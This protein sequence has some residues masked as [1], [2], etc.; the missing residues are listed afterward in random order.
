MDDL[1]HLAAILTGHYPAYLSFLKSL[2]A[3][4]TVY[5]NDS[6]LDQGIGFCREHIN[7][8]LP[9]RQTYI[10]EAG[11][12]ISLDPAA[13]P[14]EPLVYLSAHIDTVPADSR[15]WHPK[16]SPFR[17]FEDDLEIVGRGV[18]DCKAGVAFQLFLATLGR[19]QI[20]LSPNLVLTVTRREEQG[21]RSAQAIAEAIGRELPAGPN[22]YV[23][24]LENTTNAASGELQMFHGERSSFAIELVEK[25]KRLKQFLLDDANPWNPTSICPVADLIPGHLQ[26]LGQSGGHAASVP[27][28]RNLLYQL[29]IGEDGVNQAI[30]SGDPK[31]V[32]AIPTRVEYWTTAADTVHRATFDLRTT[33]NLE[34]IEREF[35]IQDLDFR[36][37]K[38]SPYG[39]DGKAQF[40]GSDMSGIVG[41]LNEAG[42]YIVTG[43]GPGLTDAGLFHNAVDS[44]LR[45]H[46]VAVAC[47]PGTG[48]Q[49]EA[50]PPRLTH[51]VNETF[52]KRS[53]LDSMIWIS[54]LLAK[55]RALR[56]PGSSKL[57]S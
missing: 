48:S 42:A 3:I 22:L 54:N 33:K 46:F 23:I 52:D 17:P 31:A 40:I 24:V 10:D 7:R 32:S 1:N 43:S 29:L 36:F 49:R 30:R 15:N 47:G 9:F 2:V 39:Y 8:H 57:M 21:G 55:L 11:N 13:D 5:D 28:N 44:E 37:V 26:E 51:G 18:S 27:R 12:L 53:G 38:Q 14:R 6:G 20:R 34:L 45:R 35:S 50:N 25:L 56:L 19:D 41:E 16:F 4:N